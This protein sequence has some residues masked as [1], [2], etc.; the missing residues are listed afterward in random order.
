MFRLIVAL[1]ILFS[2][3]GCNYTRSH[4]DDDIKN[5]EWKQE[6]SY[7]LSN[8][9][10]AYLYNNRIAKLVAYTS[11]KDKF[12]Y[13]IPKF[14]EYSQFPEEP[15][16]YEAYLQISTP[17]DSNKFSVTYTFRYLT[18][19]QYLATKGNWL[20]NDLYNNVLPVADYDMTKYS[21]YSEY[22]NSYN[23][24]LSI[25]YDQD[26]DSLPDALLVGEED[27]H[28]ALAYYAYKLIEDVKYYLPCAT[29]FWQLNSGNYLSLHVE[30]NSKE[31]DGLNNIDSI[32]T[33]KDKDFIN[34]SKA[35]T[36][37]DIDINAYAT[38]I[39]GYVIIGDYSHLF[40]AP[41]ESNQLDIDATI[42]EVISEEESRVDF[43]EDKE[44]EESDV[45]EYSREPFAYFDN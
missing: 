23:S 26:I 4:E 29:Y 12:T 37:S 25:I 24:E 30:I 15:E 7:E 19:Q 18:Y 36:E 27:N 9:N 44:E 20:L 1:V 11:S 13:M 42:S 35:Y 22:V 16:N 17:E 45:E 38:D 40:P 32:L 14:H 2:L 31:F 43:S 33:L 41:E 34:K 28:N 39:I 10:N 21:S 5:T 6:W 3:S 8:K